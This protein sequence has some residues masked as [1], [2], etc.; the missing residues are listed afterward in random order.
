MNKYFSV[1]AMKKILI[2]LTALVMCVSLCACAQRETE[3]PAT[4][5]VSLWCTA[6]SPEARA[7]GALTDEY[8]A[9]PDRAA[10]VSLKIFPSESAMAEAF[11]SLRPDLLACTYDRASSLAAGRQLSAVPGL[12][13]T[14]GEKL[15]G[16][17]AAFAGGSFIPV[18][19]EAPLLLCAPGAPVPETPEELAGAAAE[20][21]GR[22]LAV[23]QWA[24][25]FAAAACASG[26]E[27]YCELERDA[28]NGSFA[29]L[30]NLFA[31]LAYEGK[32][33][34]SPRAAELAAAGK[35]RYALVSSAEL[36]GVDIGGCTLCAMPDVYGDKSQFMSSVWGVAVTGGTGKSARGA[37]DFTAWLLDGSRLGD[38]AL[39][40]GLMPAA[41]CTDRSTALCAALFDI[42]RT[43][44]LYT[45]EAGSPYYTLRHGFNEEVTAAMERL[46]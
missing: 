34:F 22:C 43:H 17:L 41:A 45:A 10:T 16:G 2:A 19:G 5:A 6:D 27:F 14:L 36:S 15:N 40:C 30:Y 18:G 23:T 7:L 28:G 26:E 21:E 44:R 31:E 3:E 25:I 20:T 42:S 35:L 13:E 9:L 1:D 32:M 12:E 39:G 29:E 33:S 24:D 46:Y 8:N 11:N 4:D 37:A 38:A